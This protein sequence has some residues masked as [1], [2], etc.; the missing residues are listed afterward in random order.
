ME[1]F[2]KAGISEDTEVLECRRERRQSTLRQLWREIGV[3]SSG[4]S[5]VAAEAVARK[6]LPVLFVPKLLFADV[7]HFAGTTDFWE[8]QKM[9]SLGCEKCLQT[10]ADAFG[11]KS[12]RLTQVFGTLQGCQTNVSEL[13]SR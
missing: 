4:I 11:C 8:Q 2:W 5:T 6:A 1:P 7:G 13:Y 12:P 9:E 3:G 10:M